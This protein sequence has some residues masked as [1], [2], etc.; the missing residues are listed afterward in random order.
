MHI[1]VLA[2]APHPD[3]VELYCSGTLIELRKKG[4]SIGV[5][6]LTL[7]ELSTR[8]TLEMRKQE[9]EAASTVLGLAFRTNLRIPDGDISNTE[10][11]RM[12]I[13]QVLRA[14]QPETVLLPDDRDRHPDHP[15]AS[16][17]VR[18]ACFSSGLSKIE[19]TYEGNRQECFRP[20]RLFKYMLSFDA[21]PSILVDI[22]SSFMEKMKAI[23]CY[24]SQFH[25]A[26][27]SDEPETYISTSSFMEAHVARM[28]RLG[29]LIGVEYAEGFEPLQPF[30]GSADLLVSAYPK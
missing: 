2:F 30:G 29:F 26:K 23:H 9:T 7:G 28:K 4:L 11:H 3:D 27:A 21:S 18:E 17:L 5:V 24:D 6:D 15:H 8:G 16:V 1:D 13:I 19:S 25:T 22:S 12:S 14:L 10:E 20:K